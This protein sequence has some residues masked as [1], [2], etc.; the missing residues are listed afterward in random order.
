MIR[1]SGYQ[2]PN[3]NSV[4]PTATL[5]QP[6]HL[7]NI[8]IHQQRQPHMSSNASQP[9]TSAI[10]AS[11]GISV[12]NQPAAYMLHKCHLCGLMFNKIH[13][14]NIHIMRVHQVKSINSADSTPAR[15][16]PIDSHQQQS[17][18]DAS[19]ERCTN[20]CCFRPVTLRC[21][22]SPF[23]CEQCTQLMFPTD[24]DAQQQPQPSMH[25][26]QPDYESMLQTHTS[27]SQTWF[28][29]CC[30]RLMPCF[31]STV[32]DPDQRAPQ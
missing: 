31:S 20:C 13:G 23:R 21:A 30:V 24:H 32:L 27:V 25:P 28:E 26:Q 9:A 18:A 29:L 15:Q 12:A 14:L 19:A 7:Q 11:P 16:H 5:Q 6:Q 4:E 3:S 8:Q 22:T 17:M 10:V 2:H 1:I